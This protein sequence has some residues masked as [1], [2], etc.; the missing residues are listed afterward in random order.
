MRIK[1]F[2]LALLINI[3]I[4]SLFAQTWEIVKPSFSDG[5]LL[6]GNTRITFTNKDIGWL[7]TIFQ[8]EIPNGNFYKKIYKT[9]DGGLSWDA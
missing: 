6:E 4:N 1:Y 8:K 9:T 5:D 3:P 7:F 2:I